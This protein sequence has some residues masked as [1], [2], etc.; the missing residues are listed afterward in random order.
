MQQDGSCEKHNNPQQQLSCVVVVDSGVV[1]VT[2][3]V[4][5]AGSGSAV[6]EGSVVVGAGRVGVV[7]G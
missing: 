1:V 2:D 4:V 5:V 6:V 7:E 3:S